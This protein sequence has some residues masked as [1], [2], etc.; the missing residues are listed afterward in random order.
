MT[1]GLSG[2]T[3]PSST[4]TPSTRTCRSTCPPTSSTTSGTPKSTSPGPPRTSPSIPSQGA[5]C[6]LFAALL[7]PLLVSVIGHRRRCLMD[8]DAA[9]LPLTFQCGFRRFVTFQTGRDPWTDASNGVKAKAPGLYQLTVMIEERHANEIDPVS[10]WD[11]LADG[12]TVFPQKD[13]GMKVRLP[14]NHIAIEPHCSQSVSPVSFFIAPAM[15]EPL[16]KATPHANDSR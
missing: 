10:G 14:S 8:P 2:A 12:S 11:V 5:A 15:Q 9:P 3:T 6:A 16:A 4:P 13:N 7:D 1:A